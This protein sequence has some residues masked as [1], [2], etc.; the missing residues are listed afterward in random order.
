MKRPVARV[1]GAVGVFAAVLLNGV[2]WEWWTCTMFAA[3]VALLASWAQSRRNAPHASD[4]IDD[5][6]Q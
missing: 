2:G 4:E 6:H 5:L 1:G 3:G